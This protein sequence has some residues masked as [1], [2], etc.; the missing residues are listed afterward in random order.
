M[1]ITHNTQSYMQS[2][3]VPKIHYITDTDTL[4]LPDGQR[5]TWRPDAT[6]FDCSRCCMVEY[7]LSTFQ[8]TPLGIQLYVGDEVITP[9][10]SCWLCTGD[11]AIVERTEVRG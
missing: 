9:H 8:Q 3:T 2:T 4:L 5:L 6:G 10:G 11:H 7:I 1:S